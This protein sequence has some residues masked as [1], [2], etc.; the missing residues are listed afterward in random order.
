MCVACFNSEILH[1]FLYSQL[2]LPDPDHSLYVVELLYTKWTSKS[3]LKID[4]YVSVFKVRASHFMKHGRLRP[5][6]ERYL[7][8]ILINHEEINMKY[9][10]TNYVIFVVPNLGP[11]SVSVFF[12]GKNLPTKIRLRKHSI[13]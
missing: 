10:P 8:S 9:G 2:P 12:S 1:G 11:F 5:V 3:H 7:A 4:A 6:L 13:V